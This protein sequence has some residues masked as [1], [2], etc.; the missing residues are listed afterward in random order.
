[1]PEH[2]NCVFCSLVSGE[3]DFAKFW[4]DD[5]FIA[6]LDLFPNVKGQSLLI[7]KR[8]YHSDIFDQMPDAEYKDFFAAARNV[9]EILKSGLDVKRVA[10]VVEGMGVNHAHIKFYPLYGLTQSF[11]E[12]W[13]PEK[14]HFEKYEG[15]IS[16]KIGDKANIQELKQLACNIKQK[17]T[18]G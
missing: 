4:E 14:V 15:Y 10:L 8:H 7:T 13:H 6:V 3:T 11:Q 9:V 12:M 1:M 2:M 16:T 5:S 17:N 18:R